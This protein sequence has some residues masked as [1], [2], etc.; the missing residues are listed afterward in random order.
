MKLSEDIRK[1]LLPQ[2]KTMLSEDDYQGYKEAL[3]NNK[4]GLQTLDEK[5]YSKMYGYKDVWHF[6]DDVTLSDQVSKIKVPTFALGAND[7]QLCEDKLAPRKQVCAPDSNICLAQTDFGTHCC[8]LTGGLIPKS[9]YPYPCMEF[10]EFLE[11][12]NLSSATR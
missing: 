6:Y 8:H 1:Y 3:E 4:N 10:I 2:M 11:A 12:K 5:V 7:D 9:W